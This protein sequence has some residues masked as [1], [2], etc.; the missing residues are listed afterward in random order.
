MLSKTVKL[1]ERQGF[2]SG[3]PGCS[4]PKIMEYISQMKRFLCTI[5][6]ALLQKSNGE[7]KTEVAL[8]PEIVKG[9]FYMF[10]TERSVAV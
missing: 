2:L 4:V 1:V 7:E 3:N 5:V 10:P 6:V 8:C 9:I